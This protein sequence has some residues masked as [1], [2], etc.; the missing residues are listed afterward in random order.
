MDQEI[1]QLEQ[2]GIRCRVVVS[3]RRRHPGI[4][5]ADGELTLCGP[6]RMRLAD[7]RRILLENLPA[8]RRLMARR[9]TA[10]PPEPGPDFSIGSMLRLLGKSFP[11]RTGCGHPE[12]HDGAFWVHP[13]CA[14]QDEFIAL[15]RKLARQ[16]L[17]QRAARAAAAAGIDIRGIR[18]GSAAGRWGSCSSQGFL[19]FPWKLILCP[20]E[21]VDYVIAHELAHRRHMDHS[22]AFWEEVHTLCPE[23]RLRR[24]ELRIEELKL[25]LWGP[26][27]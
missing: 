25:R 27:R 10:P 21:L 14:R 19:N 20:V 13:V 6:L 3:S 22:P 23:W 2:N 24:K 1:G 9:E 7:A 15:Y 4:R 18:I 16:I 26:L 17:T 11:V 5:Y 8:V 12:F